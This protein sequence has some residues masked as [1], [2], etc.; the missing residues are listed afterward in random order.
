MNRRKFVYV[1]VAP[2]LSIG[3]YRLTSSVYAQPP[4]NQKPVRVGLVHPQSPST[5]TRGVT[6]FREHLRELGYIEG[7]SLIIETRWAEGDTKVLPALIAEVLSRH[8][9]VLVT[10]A[11]QATVA[12]KQ[13]TSVVP[14]VG[15]A[16]GDPISLGL[17]ASVGHPGGNV[18]GLAGWWTG[19]G[20][21]S[22]WV[23]LLQ[24]IIPS[25]SHVAVIVN[26][27]T[28]IAHD[29]Q[30]ELEGAR[31][32]LRPKLLFIEARE[33][34]MLPSA[35]VQAA[36]K[37]Q[38]I[39]VLPSVVYSGNRWKVT[40][41]ARQPGLPTIY[42]IRDFVEAG[43]LMSYGPDV[44]AMWQRAAEYVDKIVNGAK[45]GDLPF[46]QP[47]KLELVINLKTAKALGIPIPESI[48]LRA[49]EVIQ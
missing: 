13:G 45:P 23:Q 3:S 39:L 10:Y 16:V 7:Q 47:T 19:E 18:T 28:A 17:A 29:L 34:G 36:K 48:L 14:V 33:A 22:K 26:P 49:D 38:A 35:F 24:E 42:Y 31:P 32:A 1:L 12:A 4:L 21:A 6:A 11:T 20:V 25:L 40:A 43:G 2:A 44:T 46:E 37:G 41:L 27:D 30:R 9:D 15:V 5:A 8:V